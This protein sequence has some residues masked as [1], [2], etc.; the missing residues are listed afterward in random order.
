MIPA[1]LTNIITLTN[2]NALTN[3]KVLTNI[4]TL[5]N[6]NAITN[7][8]VLTYGKALTNSSIF[9]GFKRLPTIYIQYST[10]DYESSKP[11]SNKNWI[12]RNS[13]G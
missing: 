6:M 2:I 11:K 7:M 8:K 4:N 13:I 5:T 10:I 12:L 3:I 1:W 9:N